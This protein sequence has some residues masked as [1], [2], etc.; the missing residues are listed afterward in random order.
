MGNTQQAFLW[1][2]DHVN[3]KKKDNYFSICRETA[4]KYGTDNISLEQLIGLLL[5]CSKETAEKLAAKGIQGLMNASD[6]ELLEFKGIGQNGLLRLKGVFSF[7]KKIIE[8]IRAQ[9]PIVSSPMDVFKLL[10]PEMKYLDREHFKALLLNTKLQLIQVVT[11][12]VG[13]LDKTLIH[14][15]ELF[16]DAIKLSASCIILAHNHPSGMPQPSQE[17]IGITK[18]LIEAG[19]II[20]IEILDHIIVGGSSFK[21]LKEMGII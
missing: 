11:V 18:R 17:D 8:D 14:P 4:I 6:K 20:G 13:G 7:Y 16:K 15:R 12:S 2:D 19:K 21:S 1:G 3:P 10:A 5:H 9:S